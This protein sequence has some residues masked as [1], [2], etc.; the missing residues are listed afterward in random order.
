MSFAG[1]C[2]KLFI[3]HSKISGVAEPQDSMFLL[4]LVSKNVG[5]DSMG[6]NIVTRDSLFSGAYESTTELVKIPMPELYPKDTD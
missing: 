5:Q 6:K 1:E 4:V 2:L 3:S